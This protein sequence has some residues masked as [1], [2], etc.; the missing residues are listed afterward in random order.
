MPSYEIPG[1][2]LEDCESETAFQDIKPLSRG[3]FFCSDPNPVI[4]NPSKII[5]HFH[6]GHT[7]DRSTDCRKRPLVDLERNR[8]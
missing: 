7:T 5:V 1:F 8:S 3:F 4:L 6:T 2:G